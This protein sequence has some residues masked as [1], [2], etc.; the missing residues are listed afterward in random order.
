MLL[1]V[2]SVERPLDLIS[3]DNGNLSPDLLVSVGLSGALHHYAARAWRALCA[4]A[5]ASGFSLTYTYGGTYRTYSQQVQLFKQRYTLTVLAGRPTKQW[6]G[7]TWYQLPNTAMAAVPG[8]SNHGFG[9]A[10][11]TA[12]GS[13][14]SHATGIDPRLDWMLAHAPTY[15]WSWEAQSEP[16]HIRYVTGDHT[17]QAVL[18]Y[19]GP[20]KQPTTTPAPPE[21]DMPTN[22]H[23]SCEGNPEILVSLDG[24]GMTLLGFSS[25]TDRDT[26]VAATRAVECPVSQAQYNTFVILARQGDGS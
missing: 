17:P 15:G 13:D 26:I 12:L 16:W 8:T 11:D 24:S 6:L 1:P 22:L 2:A 14:P 25:P 18:A 10:V 7:Q 20:Q 4:A 21:D 19:E 9:L 5:S 23:V 3:A